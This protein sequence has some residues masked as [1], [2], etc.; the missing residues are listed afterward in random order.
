MNILIGHT[1]PETAY[2]VDDYPYGFRL[3]CKIRYWLEYHAKR[4]FRFVSQTTNPKRGNV[5]NKPK[6]S[7]YCRFGGCMYL[8]DAGHV[9]WAGLTE[10]CSGAEAQAWRDTYGAGV[11]EAGRATMD[12]WVAAKVA[13]DANRKSG[14]P[15]SVGLKEA[16]DAFF[17][18]AVTYVTARELQKVSSPAQSPQYTM[19]IPAGTRCKIVDG[20]FVVD[21]TSKV[22]GG[23]PHDLAH[24]YIWLDDADVIAESAN[25]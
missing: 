23:N 17:N 19:T 10:Y 15:L 4:G 3:R 2:V 13:Y 11:P 1:S 5:W 7:T 16:R 6:A 12:Q 21:D 24:Y 22:V 20:R 9:Q 18:A 8:D 25:A 14:D